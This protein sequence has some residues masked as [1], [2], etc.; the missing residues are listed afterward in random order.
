MR[1]TFDAEI[2]GPW[3]VARGGGDWFP[4]RGTAI[5]KLNEKG[6]LVAGVLYE[7]YNGANIVCHI[8]GVGNWAT[9]DF[10]NII[11]DYPFNQLGVKRITAPNASDSHAS[12]NLVKRM[13]FELECTLSQAT[14]RGDLL[15]F[16]MFRDDCRYIKG[17]YGK[18]KSGTRT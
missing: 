3:V 13:G 4:G 16:R 17:K 18:V 1:L 12:I 15:L 2:V 14:P 7:D 6:E 5:G 9:K 10:L 8:A 11:F